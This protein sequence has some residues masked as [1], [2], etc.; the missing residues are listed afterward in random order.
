M[1]SISFLTKLIVYCNSS[2]L[3]KSRKLTK[4]AEEVFKIS[5]VIITHNRVKKLLRTIKG[6]KDQE[7]KN[8]EIIIIDD[9]STD[10][11]CTYLILLILSASAKDEFGL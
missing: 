5:I 6:I 7:Y 3:R 8:Y 2:V 10:D 9:A 1:P 4:T 11:T